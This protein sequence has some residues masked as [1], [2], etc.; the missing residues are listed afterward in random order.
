[1]CVTSVLLV[2]AVGCFAAAGPVSAPWGSVRAVFGRVRLCLGAFSVVS[3]ARCVDLCGG[4]CPLASQLG[5][6]AVHVCTFAVSEN[7]NIYT[8][9]Q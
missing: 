5:E 4:S 7:K 3:V 1:V 8:H 2:L 9:I 6:P